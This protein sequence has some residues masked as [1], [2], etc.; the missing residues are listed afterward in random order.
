MKRIFSILMCLSLALS[1]T[2]AVAKTVY[3]VPNGN[4]TF[5]VTGV[6]DFGVVDIANGI[7]RVSAAKSAPI[8]L[9]INSPG[10][11]VDAGRLVIQAMDMARQR[12]SKV[13]CTVGILAAS[14]AFQLLSHCDERYA[15][16][17]SL[18]LFHPSRVFVRGEALTA[19]QM[20]IIAS[21]LN[22]I[23]VKA[24]KD[25]I[26]MMSANRKW[27]ALHN[28]NETLW[29]AEDLVNET[30]NDWLTIVDSIDAPYGIFNVRARSGAG[31]LR[32][33]VK[34]SSL[35]WVIVIIK[36]GLL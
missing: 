31:E 7:E 22:K 25:N 9:V 3:K 10:G 16:K 36:D 30:N 6:I 13:V 18:L 17:N 12:G 20:K 23:D 4:R 26:E 28:A 19:S 29:N 21:E 34:D 15:L 2:F 32:R 8:H 14:M 33:S 5:Y 11:I 27:Y 1:S 24:N 35:P